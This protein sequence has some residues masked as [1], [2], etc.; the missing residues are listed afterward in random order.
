[1][2]ARESMDKTARCCGWASALLMTTALAGIAGTPSRVAAQASETAQERGFAIPAG[3]LADALVQF[4]YQSGLQVAADG[5]LAATAGSPG[6]SGHYSP[7]EA[8]SRLLAG[9][10]LTYRFTSVGSVQLEPAPRTGSGA[11]KLGPVQVEGQQDGGAG[12]APDPTT[13][14]SGS[15]AASGATVAS[16]TPLAL[17]EIPASVSVMT[18]QRMDD[19]NVTTIQEALRYVTGVEAIDYGDSTAYFRARGNQLGIEFDGVP[20]F[21][22]LQYQPHVL[23]MLRKPRDRREIAADHFLPLGIHDPRISSARPQHLQ[24][25]R[26]IQPHGLR[27]DEAFR[28]GG[29]V[30]AEHQ[31]GHEL[32]PRAIAARADVHGVVAEGRPKIGAAGK[33]FGIAADH[34]ERLAA[35]ELLAVAG[36]RRVQIRH[37]AF[38]E[39][40]TEAHRVGGLAGAGIDD[41]PAVA[42]CFRHRGEHRGDDIRVRQAENRARATGADDHRIRG[43][44]RSERRQR[45]HP[46]SIAVPHDD[47]KSRREQALRERRA[48][49]AGADESDTSRGERA[50]HRRKRIR[51]RSFA[52]Q[53]RNGQWLPPLAG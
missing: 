39:F 14:K 20:I 1:M 53:C 16:R 38:R 22:G 43:G 8:L 10:G 44:F 45:R 11:I 30:Q 19:Q 18:R 7:A 27:Q 28:E 34:A 31:I 15:Y 26:G 47:V 24:R 33:C 12:F 29:A 3:T 6:V 17:E 21:G 46:R 36:D 42:P 52:E 50:C 9:T 4:G 2:W 51:K 37:A 41:D 13:E 48:H 32:Q 23:E 25:P 35:S 40:Q 49:K 5:G